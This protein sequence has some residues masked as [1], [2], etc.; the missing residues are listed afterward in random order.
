L[1]LL[2]LLLLLF[3]ATSRVTREQS[4]RARTASAAA[5]A[6]IARYIN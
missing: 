3:G 1:L 4:L 2:L 5:I 6:T